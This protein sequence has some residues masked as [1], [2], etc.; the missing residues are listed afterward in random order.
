MVV[1]PGIELVDLDYLGQPESI[2][3]ALIETPDGFGVVD[4]GPTTSLGTL[5]AVLEARGASV[6]DLS[7]ILLTH[8]HL[9]HAG[10]SGVLVSENP[11]IRV[12]VHQRGAR[13]LEDPAKL[14]ESATRI[15]GDKM[16][17]LWGAFVPVPAANVTVLEGGERLDLGGRTLL[18]AA[19]PGHA[20][21]HVAYLDETSG[22]AFVGDVAGERY[23]GTAFVI[24][25]T[26][27]PDIDLESWRESWEHL[28]QWNPAALFL[29]HFGVF[30][31]VAAHLDQ[32]ERRTEAWAQRVRAG[33]GEDVPDEE[34][35]RAFY[36]WA[37]TE[38]RREL[39]ELLALRYAR[40]AGVLESW[41][42]LA[43]YWRKKLEKGAA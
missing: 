23:P 15:Y 16:E 31:D 17:Y 19:S 20:W 13:H 42:G 40:S 10:G 37:L 8:I 36:A 2:A 34:K 30:P 6:A 43:R 35:A 3:T 28:R 9:D 32:L 33:L 4:P 26:P 24:P 29:T 1:A 38:M 11:D 7:W 25:V 18:V 22:T 14:L 27:P 12:F 39:P 21:H 5:R 41:T